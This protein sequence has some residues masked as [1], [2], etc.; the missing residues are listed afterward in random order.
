MATLARLLQSWRQ[1]PIFEKQGRPKTPAGR[2]GAL[3]A[4]LL[5]NGRLVKMD[6]ELIT[7]FSVRMFDGSRTPFC[8]IRVELNENGAPVDWTFAYCNDALARLEGLPREKLVGHRFF[9]IFPSGDR[10][11]LAPYYDAAYEGKECEFEDISAEIGQFLHV[12]VWPAG[13]RGYCACMLDDIR[14][15]IQDQDYR[16]GIILSMAKLYYS[17]YYINLKDNSSTEITSTESIRHAGGFGA[18]AQNM[19]NLVCRDL[20]EPAFTDEMLE[21][22]NLATLDER[23]SEKNSVSHQFIDRN[24]G[25]SEAMFIAGDRDAD[26]KL[27]HV[28]YATRTIHDEKAREIAQSQVLRDALAAAEHAN[29]AKSDFLSVISHDIRTPMNGIIGMTAIA[30]A[31]VDNPDRVRD[32]LKK[33]TGASKH[34]LSLINEVLDMSKIESG[35]I[36]LTEDKFN[37]SELVDN[38]L[39]M[40]RPQIRAKSHDLVV[41]ISNLTHEKVVGDSLRIQQVFVNLLSNAVKYTPE[42]GRINLTI[43]EKPSNQSKVGC[44]EFVFEDNGIGMSQEYVAKIFEPFTRAKDVRVERTQGTGLGMTISRNIVRRMGGDIQVE[45]RLNV[46]SRFTVTVYLKL[47]DVEAVSYEKFVNLDVL[48]ADDDPLSLES[49]CSM[50]DGFG[51]KTVGV[52]GGREAVD[53]VSLHHEQKRDFFACI[54]DWKMPD[55]DGIATARAIRQRVGKQVPIII[56]SAYDWS[57]IEQEARAA[58]VDAFISKPLFRSRLAKTFNSLLGDTAE[59]P[60]GEGVLPLK[61]LNLT[62]RRVL[63]VEDNELNAVIAKEILEMANLAVECVGDGCDAVDRLASCE[64]G[65]YDLVFMDIQMPQMNGYD[66]TRAIRSMS[67][68]YCKSVP[69]IAMTANAFAEDVQSARTVGMNEHI[70]KPLD[71]PTLARILEKWIVVPEGEAAK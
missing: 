16:Q 69:I 6:S 44:Y 65:Y 1:N 34:L 11:W 8:V 38:L 10:K 9:D 56:I 12:R 48:V 26:G 32:S 53:M 21:F 30:A 20:M 50:L 71:I 24:K 25:W 59:A 39:V 5:A 29:R 55:M 36:D 66:A 13:V 54:I 49:C 61:H 19:L 22:V 7:D 42:G 2:G 27:T 3:M 52:T 67:R 33:I 35:R 46:G 28:F 15:Q 62:G 64:D 40:M 41:N 18:D 63:L 60:G 17:T 23:L 43:S 37:L 51:M 45:S 70:A 58:G 68:S 14:E 47:Q 4:A 31:H 57:E